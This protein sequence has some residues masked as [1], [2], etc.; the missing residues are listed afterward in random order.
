MVDG[1]LLYFQHTIFEM[2]GCN[3]DDI[4]L[5]VFTTPRKIS[6]ETY[7]QLAECEVAVE[8]RNKSYISCDEI[9]ATSLLFVESIANSTEKNES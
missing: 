6:A 5:S 4:F 9:Y 8:K 7:H 1:D 3:N 2:A